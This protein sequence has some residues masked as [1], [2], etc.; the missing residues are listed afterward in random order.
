[1]AGGNASR[2][3]RSTDYD[4]AEADWYVEPR[5]CVEALA[6]ALPLAQG[7]WV[8]DPCC[9]L[10]TIPSVFAERIGQHRVIATDI[11][12]RGYPGFAGEWDA[13][14]DFCPSNVPT[15]ARVNIVA[16]PPFAIAERIVRQALVLADHRVVILQQLSF[17]A[18]RG[19]HALFTEFPPAEILILSRRPS[20][21]PGH[22][23]AELGDKAFK[24][25]TQDF[26]WIVWDR[27]HDRE[28]RVRWL[29]PESAA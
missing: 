15:G 8:W 24:G 7:S 10:G 2:N 29:S 26:C 13:T 12:D 22:M 17:L 6:D 11:I 23:I 4:R 5:W 19:R 27:P 18:S 20:M 16:N 14:S 25:G 28:T 9:G 3:H 21:P 1:M